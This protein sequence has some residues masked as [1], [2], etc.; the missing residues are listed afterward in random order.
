M[1]LVWVRRS[2]RLRGPPEYKMSGS[3]RGARRE[4]SVKRSAKALMGMRPA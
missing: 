1:L 4:S 2:G 3:V